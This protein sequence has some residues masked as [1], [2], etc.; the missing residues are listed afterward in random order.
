MAWLPKNQELYQRLE[1]SSSEVRHLFWCQ[2]QPHD[3]DLESRGLAC[4]I[5]NLVA[6]GRS[7]SAAVL[8]HRHLRK[9]GS[10]LIAVERLKSERLETGLY[11]GTRNK[12]DVTTR[13][14]S[15]AVR[16]REKKSTTIAACEAYSP[17]LTEN[18][19]SP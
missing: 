13:G 8:M 16:W 11:I 3:L 1:I 2:V 15:M 7:Y 12:R 18:G 9:A 14:P 5:R 6:N 4:V 17:D 10:K 19:H